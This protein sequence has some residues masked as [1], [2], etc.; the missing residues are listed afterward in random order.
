M[1]PG[2]P[3]SA[4]SVARF[5]GTRKGVFTMENAPKQASAGIVKPGEVTAI[6]IMTLISGILNIT[7]GLGLIVTFTLGI[8]TII[9]I[10]LALYPI[11]LGILEII[12]AAKLLPNP[13][14]PVEPAQ[15][16]AIMQ[17]IDIVFGNVISLAAGI[18]ALVFYSDQKVKAYF[19]RVSGRAV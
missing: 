19:A 13:P 6:A 17:I 18:L 1:T 15:Y 7:L 16:L 8:V 5:M 12:Y 4:S 9:C 3:T 14:K 11:I 10:P 2:A